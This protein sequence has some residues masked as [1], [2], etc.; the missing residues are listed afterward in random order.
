MDYRSLIYIAFYRKI[1]DLLK[2]D[3]I[4]VAYALLE[5]EYTERI[6]SLKVK[7]ERF[8]P[9]VCKNAIIVLSSLRVVVMTEHDN[10]TTVVI[11]HDFDATYLTRLSPNDK[12]FTHSFTKGYTQLLAYEARLKEEM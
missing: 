6:K 7:C 3:Y 1:C 11:P 10:I 9:H 12:P 2:M 4:E 5:L 8:V